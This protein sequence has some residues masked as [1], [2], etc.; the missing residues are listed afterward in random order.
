MG[1]NTVITQI[2]SL[3]LVALVGFYGGKKNIID[4]NL[5]NGLSKLLVEITT[6]FLVISSFSISYGSNVANNIIRTFI[7]SFIIFILT[8]LLVKPL[9]IGVDK[10]KKNVLEF[11]M[12][13]SNCGF[14]GFPVAQSIFGNEGVVYAAI[15]NMVFN[16]FVWTYGVMLFNNTSSFKEVIKSLKNPGIVSAVIGLLIMIFSIK[17]PPIFMSTMKMVGSLTTPISMLIIGSLLSR[18]E[19]SKIIKDKSMYYGSLI[20]LILIPA[21]LYLVSLLFKEHSMVLKTLI[22]MQAMP[23]GAFT[24]IFAENFNKN[25]EYS[26]FIVSFSSLL[27]IVT[28]PIVIKLFI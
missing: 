4:E 26:A 16:I 25:K 18:S 23:A 5:S 11:A 15:F 17:I 3:F 6:P 20:K 8:P 13:F 2:I 7:Y 1:T 14:M 22:L 19:L 21:A 24:T 10:S 12:V 28:I 27:S 9:L